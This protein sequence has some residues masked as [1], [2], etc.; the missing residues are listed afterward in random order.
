M[1]NTALTSFAIVHQ[2][3][4]LNYRFFTYVFHSL[5]IASNST[6]SVFHIFQRHSNQVAK[7][8]DMQ[9]YILSNAYLCN[10]KKVL[11]V[12]GMN[13]SVVVVMRNYISSQLAA[14]LVLSF[15]FNGLFLYT[16]FFFDRSWPTFQQKILFFL[17][18][19]KI[20]IK[21][22][23]SFRKLHEKWFNFRYS[24]ELIK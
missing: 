2:M 1:Q 4:S 18:L 9:H 10:S 22:R 19:K 20:K 14:F 5:G 11:H 12:T 21:D 16:N 13:F 8:T 15:C 3:L 24:L 17:S 7:H 23:N 6:K